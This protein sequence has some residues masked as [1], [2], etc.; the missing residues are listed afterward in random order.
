[1]TNAWRKMN[2][3]QFVDG[4]LKYECALEHANQT[5]SYLWAIHGTGRNVNVV[6]VQGLEINT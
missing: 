1:M 2:G 6:K 5:V 3:Y 4:T